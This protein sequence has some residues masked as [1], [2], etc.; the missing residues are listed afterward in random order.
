[1]ATPELPTGKVTFLFTDIEGSTRI[2]QALGDRRYAQTLAR[3]D[4]IVRGAVEESGVVVKVTGDSFFAVFTEPM[5]AVRAAATA[6]C[7]LEETEWPDESP[8]RVRMG[9]HIGQGVVG[10]DDYVGL[11]VHR[12]SRISDAAHGGQILLSS[13]IANTIAESLPAHLTIR[14][15]GEHRLKGLTRTENVLQL[16]VEGLNHEFPPLRAKGASTNRLPPQLTSFVG[17]S[18]EI[19][20]VLA[21]LDTARLVTLTGPGGT[22]KTRLS[23]EAAQKAAENYADGA[24]FV[25]LETINDPDLVPTAILAGIGLGQTAG[26]VLPTDHLRGYLADKEMLILLDNFEHILNA[27]GMV[28]DLLQAAPEVTFI[29]SSRAPLRL[30][31]EREYPV[32]PLAT[33]SASRPTNP[34]DISAFEGIELFTDRAAAVAPAFRLT[35]EN[36]PAIAALTERLDGLPLAIELAASRMRLLTPQAMLDRLDNRLLANP[37]AD[38]PERQQTII[39]TIGWSYDLLEAPAQRLFERC[40]V[41]MGGGGL[42]DIETVAGGRDELGIDILDGIGTLVDNS[43]LKSTT[44]DGEPRF[45]MLVVVREFAYGALVARGEVDGIRRRHAQLFAELT[46]TAGPWLLSSRQRHWLDVL[47]RDHDNI[48]SALEWAVENEATDMALDMVSNLWRFWQIRGHLLE[49]AERVDTALALP[50]G[51]PRSRAKALEAKGGV[52]YWRGQWLE[53]K[54]PYEEALAIMREHGSESDLANALY[55]ASFPIGFSGDHDGALEM[56]E[57]SRILAERANDHHGIGRAHWG[58]ADQDIYRE[59]P[60]GAIDHLKPAAA[61]FEKVDAPFDLAWTSFLTAHALV[62][63]GS[64]K[65]ARPFIDTALP[66]FVAAR[67]LSAIVLVLDLK[68]Q[69]V[70]SAGEEEIAARMIGASETLQAQTGALIT[71]MEI[72]KYPALQRLSADTRPEI[73]RALAEGRAMSA[74]EAMALAVSS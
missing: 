26:S 35:E 66:L 15:L 44:I 59:N 6:Q 51:D 54:A 2:L 23:I 17:R 57:E 65:E 16:D 7:T 5:D 27:A 10:G 60:A 22:G 41:F 63:G 3:H 52:A 12:A 32:P 46:R 50:G 43:L 24:H 74:D 14:N 20:D 61:E 48:R 18:R 53:A 42:D 36:L 4:Q 30:R 1:V 71:D 9:L 56:L 34:T 49:A 39:N 19:A 31:G 37:G 64:F 45:Q 67:D 28:G 68:A 70:L 62:L 55:N 8:I 58:L 38:I 40:S 21:L 47:D 13:D 25:P 69:I 11:D 29:V 72:N 33:P 73:I